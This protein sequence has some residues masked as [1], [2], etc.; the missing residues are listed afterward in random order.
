MDELLRGP[1]EQG[2]ET[3]PL[4]WKQDMRDKAIVP[5]TYTTYWTIW[6]RTLYVAG[7]RNEDKLRPYSLRVT[8]GKNLDGENFVTVLDTKLT[9]SS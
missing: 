2:I 5:I 7:I 4:K 1:A 3:V 9:A 6:N 8:A